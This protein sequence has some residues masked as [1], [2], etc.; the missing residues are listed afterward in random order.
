MKRG[1][2]DHPKMLRLA[3]CI[4]RLLASGG[5]NLPSEVCMP[6]AC[7]LV[8]R[9]FHFT[10]RYAANGAI[11]KHGDELIAKSIG[12]SLVP[13]EII[14]ALTDSEWLDTDVDGVRL[15]VHDWHEHSDDGADK[16]LYDN[17]KLYANGCRPRRK[18]GFRKSRQVVTSRDKSRLV[19]LSEPVSES[20]P[21]SLSEPVSKPLPVSEAK[22]PTSRS[23]PRPGT[24][25]ADVEAVAAH[26]QAKYPRRRFGD[27]GRK[28]V[29]ARLREGFTP[30]Q[31]CLAIDG[32]LA[33]PW[34]QGENDRGKCY[35]QPR[36]VFKNEAK[37]NDFL[38][39][40]ECGVGPVVS[41]ATRRTQRAK[42]GVIDQLFKDED[43]GHESSE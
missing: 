19:R 18:K 38:E 17:R 5:I 16:W 28:L 27:E 6:L 34:H 29:A 10:A 20:E 24:R 8:E 21:E 43:D 23:S 30:E 11:G 42:E 26:Y 40:A 32:C 1:T 14:V 25:A 2:P 39:I 36:H 3:G 15:Y 37:V 4:H 31:L 22:P 35:D 12:W 41:E 9:L 13:G 7:G 33:D